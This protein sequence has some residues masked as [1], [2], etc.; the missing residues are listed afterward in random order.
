[1]HLPYGAAAVTFTDFYT[2][3]LA[4]LEQAHH[5]RALKAATGVDFSSNDYL[6]L[7]GSNALNDAARRGLDAGLAV[8]SGGSRLLRGNAPEHEALEA[9]AARFFGCEAALFVGSGY[10][11]NTLLFSTLP[12][13]Q[14]RIFYD[15]LVHASAHDG[16]R[17]SRAKAE[18]F[19][20]NDADAA[21]DAIARWRANGGTGTPFIAFETL[22]SMDG[23]AA[24][25]TQ[26]ASLAERVG[27]MLL[28]D[29]AHA[30]G[31]LG[32]G[33]RGLAASLHG[34]G[35]TV[36]LAT[37]GKALGSE[38]ALILSS[39]ILRDFLINRG[40][41]FIFSTAPSPLMAAVVRES[42]A[43]VADADAE[44][45]RLKA[46]VA[47]AG[48]VLT[49]LGI[50]PTGSHIQPVMIGDDAR[51]M[52]LAAALQAKGFD[53]RGIRPPTVPRGTARLR[54]SITLNVT[55]QDVANLA[56]ALKEIL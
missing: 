34:R 54:L 46:L 32:P 44:R 39:A 4:R 2:R 31:A 19:S 17:L 47:K 37:C 38:G 30:V 18:P 6:G 45:E 43:I 16:M 28:V 33:G 26:F 27:A 8:G 36:V 29:E 50:A 1:M 7:A 5:R 55:E 42:L 21:A 23:T 53:V 9:D 3:D 13:P 49:P 56:S 51:A 22:Y 52:H 35:D 12:Q 10:T 48:R 11:A 24:P 20:H 40:R 41:G 14:D 25:V 15:A